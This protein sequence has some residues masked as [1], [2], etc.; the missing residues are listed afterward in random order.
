MRIRKRQAAAE[1]SDETL[2]AASIDGDRRAFGSI[3]SRY[4]RLLCSLA[5]AS[6]GNLSAS[7][8]LAQET[9]V[10]AWKQLGSLREAE[11]L[12][13]W[14]CG[15]LRHKIRRHQRSESRQPL[16][17]SDDLGDA[18]TFESHDVSAERTVMKRQEEALLWQ[19]LE[20][21]PETYRETLVLYYREERSVAQ[22]AKQLDLSEAAA[23]QRLS[24]GRK[25]LQE[26]MLAF[27]EGALER[28]TPGHA[29]T[30]G[31]AAVV[32][33]LSPPAK[34]AGAG[35]TAVK[36]G[37]MFKWASIVTVLAS[38]SGLISS[39][40]AVRAS[41]DQ[42]RTRRERKV[43]VATTAAFLGSALL[44]VVT[45]FGLRFAALES[46]GNAK[47]LAALAQLTVCAFV[48]FY[49]ALTLRMSRTNRRLRSAERRRHPDK[50]QA[51]QDRP[52]SR[53]RVFKSRLRLLGVPLVH[54]QFAT[55]EEDEGPAVG[56]I[57]A[58]E[59][60]YGL[61]F[62]WGGLA[63]APISVGIVA[64]GVL[65]I[66]AIGLGLL[67]MGTVG[68]GWIAMGASAVGY[69]AYG[70]LSALGWENAFSQGFSV[71]REAALG[72]I[73]Y[74]KAVNNDLAATLS[75]LSIVSDTY[76]IVLGATA[77]LVVIPAMLYSRAV[78]K[79]MRPAR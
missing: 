73:A 33:G 62:A 39:F 75:D 64:V 68:V 26:R 11:K 48:V 50:F 10:E 27:V 55:P 67:A 65:S 53:A 37:S 9:F 34:A 52:G 66:G 77:C 17:R 63:V 79:R 47:L 24:R 61:L 21:V 12:K 41:L 4:Q 15:I 38:V 7:E 5:Y 3:V 22:V 54:I 29:F 8:D 32:A 44:F 2:V 23:K 42:S 56:W 13:A 25:L 70:S 31:V 6:L 20:S 74:A 14:L 16:G 40:F 30:A 78:R 1:P 19:A 35:A 18:P 45:M 46:I 76:L 71:A 59:V 28:S 72:P 60:A 36:L 43:V 57:A 49:L 58:G 51:P 69:K